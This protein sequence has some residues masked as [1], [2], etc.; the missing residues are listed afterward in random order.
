MAKTI[1]ITGATSGIGYATALAFA[2]QGANVAI[3]GRRS[4]RGGE[5]ATE[6][7]LLVVRLGFFRPTFRTRTRS[8]HL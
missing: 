5:A 4:D 6:I 3:S 1:V 8:R 2:R 7:E